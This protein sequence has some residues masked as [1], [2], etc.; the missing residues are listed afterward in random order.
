[1][2]TRKRPEFPSGFLQVVEAAK[3]RYA[4]LGLKKSKLTVAGIGT[5]VYGSSFTTATR[6]ILAG[7]SK[8]CPEWLVDGWAMIAALH[9]DV[10]RAMIE[11]D[12]FAIDR[13]RPR[14]HVR[15]RDGMGAENARRGWV[16][17]TPD[18]IE[19]DRARFDADQQAEFEAERARW[20]ESNG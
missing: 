17:L 15:D 16:K 7:K 1:M 4:A 19:Y 10:V 6:R 5:A 18:G 2:T 8:R 11:R 14:S 9:P 13:G 3:A 12:G 20:S